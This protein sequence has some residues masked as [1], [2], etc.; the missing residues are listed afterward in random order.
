MPYGVLFLHNCSLNC[1]VYFWGDFFLPQNKLNEWKLFPIECFSHRV[2]GKV[3]LQRKLGSASVDGRWMGHRVRSGPLIWATGLLFPLQ[4]FCL[5][6]CGTKLGQGGI[7]RGV[8]REAMWGW[9]K[10]ATIRRQKEWDQRG[11]VATV[12]WRFVS[13][14]CW[15]DWPVHLWGQLLSLLV[16]FFSGLKVEKCLDASALSGQALGW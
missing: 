3:M 9:G 10:R 12:G 1:M 6:L 8:K 2:R 15:Q 16:V 11:L 5:L 7:R 14:R 13:G 4:M